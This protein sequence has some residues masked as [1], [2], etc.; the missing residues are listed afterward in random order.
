LKKS[1]KAVMVPS[2]GGTAL[3]KLLREPLAVH[4]LSRLKRY[5]APVQRIQAKANPR[6]RS[7]V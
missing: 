3:G 2:G 4:D 7:E 6:I 1:I 5:R